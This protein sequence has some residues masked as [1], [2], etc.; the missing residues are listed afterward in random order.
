MMLL[1]GKNYAGADASNDA[2]RVGGRAVRAPTTSFFN[3]AFIF[4][5]NKLAAINK[6][7]EVRRTLLLNTILLGVFVSK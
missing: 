5:E 3:T 7:L 6:Q 2:S 1:F 4:L